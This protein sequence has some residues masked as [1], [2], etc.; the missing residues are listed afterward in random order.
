MLGGEIKCILSYSDSGG[1]FKFN[2]QGEKVLW[3]FLGTNIP[4]ENNA[5]TKDVQELF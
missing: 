3:G 2:K 1:V 5:H 4:I